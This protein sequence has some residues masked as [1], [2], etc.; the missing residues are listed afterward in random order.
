MAN[1]VRE[2]TMNIDQHNNIT[3]Y[4][5]LDKDRNRSFE[6]HMKNDWKTNSNIPLTN[7]DNTMQAWTIK[8]STTVRPYS[9][10]GWNTAAVEKMRPIANQAQKLQ[11]NIIARKQSFAKR[12]SEWV[13]PPNNYDPAK[14]AEIRSYLRGLSA[15]E[16]IRRVNETPNIANVILDNPVA[17]AGTSDA[18]IMKNL[19]RMAIL[20]NVT[21]TYTE[22]TPKKPSLNDPVAFDTDKDAG[23]A[24]A[25][26]ALK[27]LES[28]EQH[29]DTMSKVLMQVVEYYA[30][31][32][33]L[34]H[35]EAFSVMGLAG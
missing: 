10:E 15:A 14:A 24:Y 19:Q 30:I 31:A 17:I 34:T 1:A 18:A 13:R 2:F 4:S 5:V 3:S 16:V 29:A 33:N 28:S 21:E 22:Q 12:R 9:D 6:I 26:E 35:E 7:L 11:K 23:K 27:N 8:A 20:H 32:T 25:E